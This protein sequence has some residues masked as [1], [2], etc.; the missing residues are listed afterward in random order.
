MWCSSPRAE[1]DALLLRFANGAAALV[2]GSG[3]ATMDFPKE[4]V[5]AITSRG[6][7]VVDDFV[8]LRAFGGMNLPTRE[9][10]PGRASRT[11]DEPWVKR[12]GLRGLEGMIEVR[13]SLWEAWRLA[14]DPPPAVLPNFL[15]DQGW[16]A[17]MESFVDALANGASPPHAT[18]EDARSASAVADAAERSRASGQVE[19]VT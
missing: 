10:F 18:L 8:E 5:E 19:R 6:A 3:H 14:P 2:L 7:V 1:D 11:E 15:R 13:R 9:T 4:R 17:S 12:L 16:A